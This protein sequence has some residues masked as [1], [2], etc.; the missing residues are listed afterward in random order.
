MTMIAYAFRQHRRIAK[1][2]RKKDPT[3]RHLSQACQPCATPLSL[4]S[5]GHQ[6][7]DAHTA[8]DKSPKRSGVNK[9]AQSSARRQHCIHHLLHDA[10]LQLGGQVIYAAGT[11]VKCQRN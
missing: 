3:G 7:R 10:L 5:F 8:E 4:S 9:S 2:G 6:I 11:N 1:A